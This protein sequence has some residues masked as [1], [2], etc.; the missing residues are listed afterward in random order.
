ME[1]KNFVP[2]QMPALFEPSVLENLSEGLKIPEKLL[3]LKMGK[4]QMFNVDV[5]NVTNHEIYLRNRTLLGH[6]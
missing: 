3:A 6:L 4:T 5:E 2:K 1:I